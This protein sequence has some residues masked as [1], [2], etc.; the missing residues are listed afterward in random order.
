MREKDIQVLDIIPLDLL[1]L[2]VWH[3]F[4]ESV[5]SINPDCLQQYFILLTM[6]SEFWE[7]H[8]TF[9]LQALKELSKYKFIFK[10]DF[11]PGT[12]FSLQRSKSR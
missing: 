9:L 5:S 2:T 10:N 3:M 11:V 1:P 12:L 7:F 4:L 6:I 8:V